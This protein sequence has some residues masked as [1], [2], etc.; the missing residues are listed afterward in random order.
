[1]PTSCSSGSGIA[2]TNSTG[3]RIVAAD[4]TSATDR[5]SKS[6]IHRAITLP[7]VAVGTAPEASAVWL[8]RLR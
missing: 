6:S 1:M 2:R 7:M 4:A 5:R 3:S 8:G